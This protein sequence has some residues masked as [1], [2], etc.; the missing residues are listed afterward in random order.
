MYVCMCMCMCMCVCVI[1]IPVLFKFAC[2]R[3][4]TTWN[5]CLLISFLDSLAQSVN[6]PVSFITSV[7]VHVTDS[8]P[9]GRIVVRCY[10]WHFLNLLKTVRV[11]LRSDK[12][13]GTVIEDRSSFNMQLNKRTRCCVSMATIL[14]FLS[15]RC[16]VFQALWL[17]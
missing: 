13:A 17:D 1:K 11:W 16:E 9:A 5:S 14:I 7:C 8:A 4:T 12:I 15:L 2:F 6:A 10:V 3:T